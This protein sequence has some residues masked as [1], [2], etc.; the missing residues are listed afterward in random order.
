MEKFNAL[1]RGMQ[2]ML[3]G[4]VLLFI[5]LFLP[6]QGY[7]GPFKDE[8][9]ALGGDTT[10][11]AWHGLGGWL[12]GL[13]TILLVAWIVAR[14]A[15]VNIPIPV[16]PAATAAVLGALILLVAILKSLVDDFSSWASWVGV[17]LAIVIAVGAWL[18][19]QAA[20]GVEHLKSQIPSSA[21]QAASAPAAAPAAVS[22]PPPAPAAEA[23]PAEPPPS[24]EAAPEDATDTPST[25]RET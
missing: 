13:L 3:V 25:E 12:L 23:A 22:P 7:S 2:I 4:G 16:S 10:F 19:V 17:A 20:G 6:W 5:D 1:G 11:T 18:E 24:T 21:G 14:L 8:I 9:E 15:V